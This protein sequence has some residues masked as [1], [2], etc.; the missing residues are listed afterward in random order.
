MEERLDRLR[1]PRPRWDR[2]SCPAAD[3][4]NGSESA[5]VQSRANVGACKG[6]H[7]APC[8]CGLFGGSCLAHRRTLQPRYRGSR[9][10]RAKPEV[11]VLFAM[12]G[13]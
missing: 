4:V 7:D 13:G 6:K 12:P 11:V 9:P 10:R 5:S 3:S 2:V 8:P 1:H